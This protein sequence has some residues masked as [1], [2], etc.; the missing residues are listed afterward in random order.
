MRCKLGAQTMAAVSAA[1]VFILFCVFVLI[2]AVGFFLWFFVAVVFGGAVVLFL[3]LF[4]FFLTIFFV[5]VD[6]VE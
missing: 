4:D 6:Q 5:V 3:F 1:T 2:F